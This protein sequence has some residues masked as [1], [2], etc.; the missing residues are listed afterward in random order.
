MIKDFIY[1]ILVVVYNT[2]KLT[3]DFPA[4][5]CSYSFPAL[6]ICSLT[7]VYILFVF[8][9]RFVIVM[10]DF[11]FGIKKISA[12]KLSDSLV[13]TLLVREFLFDIK[14]KDLSNTSIYLIT[15]F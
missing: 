13:Y 6:K 2:P 7:T 11:T 14:K 10:Y 8:L 15:L 1:P 5:Q 9:C 3:I 12:Y 4:L